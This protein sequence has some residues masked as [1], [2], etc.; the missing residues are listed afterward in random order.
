MNHRRSNNFGAIEVRNS[1]YT[2]EITGAIK[3]TSDISNSNPFFETER[4]YQV[5][6]FKIVP[7]GAT[8][9]MP[10]EIRKLLEEN[11]I[12]PGILRR[13]FYLMKGQGHALY[14]IIFENGKRRRE[15]IEDKVIQAWLD[16]WNVE[17]YLD[18]VSIDYFATQG[19]FSKYI[20]NKGPRIGEQGKINKLEHV[21]TQR[22]C[23]EWPDNQGNIKH[24]I[25]GDWEMPGLS[26]FTSYP[27]FDKKRVLDMPV[28]MAYHHLYSFAREYYSL[29]G[30]QGSINWIKRSSDI[31]KVL[32]NL[33]NNSL[34]IKWHIKSPMAYW[35]KI[36][37]NLQEQCSLK[38][39]AYDEKMI[40][41]VKDQM[42]VNL[43]DLLTGVDNVGKFFESESVMNEFGKLE[44][45][46]IIP[47]D[48]KVK[49]FIDAQLNISKRSDFTVA[50]GLGLSPSLSNLSMDGNLSSGSEQLYAMKIHMAVD[51]PIPER[52]ITA[53]INDAIKV[54]FPGT[55]IKLGFYQEIIQAEES[56][57][58]Q[59]RVKN[60]V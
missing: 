38:G 33:T 41:D 53:A 37:Q 49:D 25:V 8:N 30:F 9:N 16:D 58:P 39:V 29:P 4:P 18:R 21:G 27:V 24:I 54:N 32:E 43:S 35:E 60:V 6:N 56:I 42:F 22:A 14:K 5:G 10:I 45:W 46:E 51:N 52:I 59:N 47:I 12:A 34:N 44:G 28:S 3:R 48:M 1:V 31:P 13:Q 20:R 17:Q 36:R 19:C 23:L 15:Y 50:S 2:Y 26:S 7:R 55:D 11:H 57:S 40:E